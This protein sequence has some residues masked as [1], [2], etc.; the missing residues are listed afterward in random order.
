MAGALKFLVDFYKSGLSVEDLKQSILDA[1]SAKIKAMTGGTFKTGAE[2]TIIN[3][4]RE[5]SISSPMVLVKIVEA[6]SG[7]GKYAGT[8][9]RP[10]T[11]KSPLVDTLAITDVGDDFRSCLVYNGVELSEITHD[12]TDNGL[13]AFPFIGFIIDIY[14]DGRPIVYI[15][16]FDVQD[17]VVIP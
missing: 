4:Q 9:L 7:G 5:E 15:N 3:V 12:L 1:K 17:C 11:V 14:S 2:G 10:S 8:I 13:V 6:E 16:G